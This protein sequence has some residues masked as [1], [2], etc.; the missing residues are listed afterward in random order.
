MTPSVPYIESGSPAYRRAVLALFLAG[1]ATFSLLYCVQPL[2]PLFARDYHISPAHAALPLSVTTAALAVAVFVAGALS[3]HMPRRALMGGSLVAAALCNIAAGFAQPWWLLVTTRLA[4]GIALG[5]VPAVAMAYLAEEIHPRDLG[6]AMGQY[7][8][9]TALG[10]MAGRFGIGLLTE[11]FSWRVAISVLGALCLISALGFVALLPPS[12]HFTV[13]RGFDRRAHLAIWR[14]QLANPA[15]LR[16][17]GI[18]FVLMGVFV[19]LFNYTGFRLT[20]APY[21][22]SQ[23]ANALIYLTYISGIFSS[24]LA[25]RMADRHGRRATLLATLAIILAG[26]VLTLAPW[27]PLVVAGIGLVTIGFF[28]GHAV[29]GG[30]VGAMAG[31]DKGHASALYLLFYYVGSSVLGW[32]GG[33]FWQHQGWGGVAGL[34]GGVLCCGLLLALRIPEPERTRPFA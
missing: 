2:L 16:L 29:A 27:L 26:V 33:A 1:F 15:L 4:E 30:W 20:G 14:G 23:T 11:W 12:R 34:T 10:G 6:K 28:A 21:H 32:L 24:A 5:G 8:G 18:G 31:P 19:T 22:L 17:F 7:V 25:G 3:Q 9:G 13:K